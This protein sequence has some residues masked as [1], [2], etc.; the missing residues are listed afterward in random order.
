MCQSPGRSGQCRLPDFVTHLGQ[1][2]TDSEGATHMLHRAWVGDIRAAR[3]AGHRP[4]TAPMR[5][6]APMPP[7]QARAG[8]TTSSCLVEA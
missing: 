7:P 8:M 1:R 3:R 5:M 6:A 2:I 4:A